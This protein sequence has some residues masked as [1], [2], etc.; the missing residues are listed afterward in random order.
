MAVPRYRDEATRA[1][2]T[3]EA[4]ELAAATSLLSV[5]PAGV[6]SPAGR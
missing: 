3:R 2:Q 1:N 5:S 6:L 4:V